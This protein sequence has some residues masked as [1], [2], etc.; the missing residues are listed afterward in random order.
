MKR[1]IF[2]TGTTSGMGRDLAIIFA[3]Q[4]KANLGISGRNVE[5]LEELKKELVNLGSDV[6]IYQL[7]VRDSGQ[8]KNSLDNF[9]A[10]FGTI[11]VIVNNAGLGE[12][13][14]LS[15]QSEEEINTQID[16]NIKGVVWG[17]KYA[18]EYMKKQ[19][20]GLIIN[21]ASVAAFF[22]L[23]NW[24]IYCATKYAVYGF[25]DALRRE[26]AQ[27]NIKVTTIHPGPVR[28]NFFV[29]AESSIDMSTSISSEEAAKQIYYASVHKPKRVIMPAAFVVIEILKKYIPFLEDLMLRLV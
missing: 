26:L 7:D 13:K 6:E 12:I 29:N 14:S 23:K 18:S 4:E 11:D 3:K 27:F 5:K 24:T 1:N 15:D 22:G 10:K 17:S 2:I 8:F 16:T 21:T 19:K 28:T 25:S 20:S 9:I